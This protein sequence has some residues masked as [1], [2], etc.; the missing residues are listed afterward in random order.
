M[1][2]YTDTLNIVTHTLSLTALFNIKTESNTRA[3][4]SLHLRVHMCHIEHQS[5]GIGEMSL[6]NLKTVI[7]NALPI[8]L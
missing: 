5:T 8:H 7:S 2:S 6:N 3:K 1:K 4:K